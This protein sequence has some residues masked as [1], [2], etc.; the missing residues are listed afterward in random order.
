[1]QCTK[2]IQDHKGYIWI[3]TKWGLSKYDGILFKNYFINNGLTDSNI[4]DIKE[5]ENGDIWALTSNGLSVIR[6]DEIKY[7]P[8]PKGLL[9]KDDNLVVNGENIWVIEG[10]YNQKIIKFHNGIFEEKYTAAKGNLAGLSFDKQKNKIVFTEVNN[11]GSKLYSFNNNTMSLESQITGSKLIFNYR[12]SL[13]I[14]STNKETIIYKLSQKDTTQVLNFDKR[15]DIIK[16]VNDSTIL[17]STTKFAS[18]MPVHILVNDKL[19]KKPNYFDQ[20]ND[21][22]QDNEGNTWV[23]SETGLYKI[24]PFYNYTEKDNMPNYVWSVQEDRSNNIWFASFNN[25][26]LFYLNEDKVKKYPKD[27][28][29]TRFYMGGLQMANGNNYFTTSNGVFVYDGNSISDLDLPE[30]EAVLSIFEDSANSKLYF[31][32]YKGLFIKDKF[33]NYLHNKNFIKGK[34]ELILKIVKN[35][36][37]ELW[38]IT[39]K[40]FGTI[41]QFGELT[42]KNEEINSGLS[43]YADERGNLWIGTKNGFY[44]YDYKNIINIHHAELNKMIGSVIKADNNHIVYGGLRGIGMLNLEEFYQTYEKLENTNSVKIDAE[45]FVSYYSNS[46]GFLG[47]EV[48]QNGMFKDSKDRVWVPTNS[49]VVMF[50]PKDLKKDVNAPKVYITKMESSSDNINWTE[51]NVEKLLN[52]TSNNVRVN[53]VGI[54][55][56]SSKETKYKYRLMGFSDKWMNVTKNRNVTFT[57]LNPGNYTFEL[58]AKKS[59]GNWTVN[60]IKNSFEVK[61]AFWQTFWFQ[62]ICILLVIGFLYQIITFIYN[63]RKRK[64]ALHERLNKLQIKAI[65]S[66]LYPHLLFNAASATGSVIYKENKERAYDF[67]VKLSQ[68]MRRAL[69][70]NNKPYKSLQE[71]LEFVKNYLELQKIRFYDRFDYLIDVDDSINMEIK[72]PQMVIQTYVENAIKHGLEP[73]KKGGLLK[74]TFKGNQKNIIIIVED[75]GVGV[76]AAKKNAKFGTQSGLK[77]MNEIYEIHNENSLPKISVK[78]IDLYKLKKEGT[79]VIIDLKLE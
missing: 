5:G 48:G 8:A 71:E 27:F 46:H 62:T 1:M 78:L 56:S 30:N 72:I 60:A 9:F 2:I 23:A 18:Q 51:F 15:V 6:N 20:I 29:T 66:Q 47:E 17:F 64:V 55:Y 36:K 31:G 74:I 38:F 53:Y 24:T 10:Y 45:N 39:K 58:K 33:G 59:N 69:V 32:S 41:N 54:S 40:S 21:L 7:F 35:K 76:I 13:A 49:N 79:K 68:L 67:V 65:Q 19:F 37:N 73:L 26:N 42:Y 63:Q 14:K 57:N 50:N 3:G 61:A 25:D 11:L 34:E 12:N 77:I 52:N 16:R 4:I 43:I 75:N 44:F 28:L 70:D 22:L